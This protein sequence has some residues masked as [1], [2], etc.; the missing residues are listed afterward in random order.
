M[1]LKEYLSSLNENQNLVK[2]DLGYNKI[3]DEGAE[4]IAE[5]LKVNKS[6]ATLV[7]WGNKIGDDGAK[8]ISR[9]FKG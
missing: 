6:L 4:A 7:L 3:G 9:S 1:N 8:A 2:M 5:A